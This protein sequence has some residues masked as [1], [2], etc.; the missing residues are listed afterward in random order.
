MTHSEAEQVRT[1]L[2]TGTSSGIGR[3]T[4][5]RLLGG[6]WKVIGLDGAPPV[7][8]HPGFRHIETDLARLDGLTDTLAGLGPFHALVHAAGFMRTG[9]LGALSA[10]EGA[11]MWRVHVEAAEVLANIIV[12]EMPREGRIVLIGSRTA[13][14]AAGRSQYAATKSALIGLAR[15]WAIELIQRGITVNVV[16]PAATDTPFLRDPARAA[17]TP[18]L[19]PIGRFIDPVEVAALNEFLLGRDAGAI[20]G[21]TITVCGGASL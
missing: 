12:P 1:A 9:R 17:T 11:D 4:A 14:G 5:D 15:S 8:T 19:P 20:T 13:S 3:A 7:I 10:K 16:A 6:S 18:V 2:V 21:Q